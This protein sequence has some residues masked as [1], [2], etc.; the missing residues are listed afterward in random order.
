MQ[1]GKLTSDST[2]STVLWGLILP[3]KIAHLQGYFALTRVITCGFQRLHQLVV[4]GFAS[5]Q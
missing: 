1:P 3:T 2:H 4:I 5:Y